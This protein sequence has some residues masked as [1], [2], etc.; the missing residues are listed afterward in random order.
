MQFAQERCHIVGVQEARIPSGGRCSAGYFVLS[1]G[2]DSGKNLGVELW[3]SLHLPYGRR[4]RE[5]LYF[6]QKETL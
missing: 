3:A 5:D 4:G 1:S 2:S 6:E